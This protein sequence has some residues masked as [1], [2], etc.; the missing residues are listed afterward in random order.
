MWTKKRVLVISEADGTIRIVPMRYNASHQRG[1]R[2]F[3]SALAADPAAI[4]E[5]TVP[6]FQGRSLFNALALYRTTIEPAGGGSHRRLRAASA[7]PT[8][9]HMIGFAVSSH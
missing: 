5:D 3:L 2:C 7:G 6:S 1:W 8:R 4:E 9:P